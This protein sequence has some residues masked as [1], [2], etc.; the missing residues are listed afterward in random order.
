LRVWRE[1]LEEDDSWKEGKRYVF[2]YKKAA[3]SGD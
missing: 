1:V 3:S 2:P